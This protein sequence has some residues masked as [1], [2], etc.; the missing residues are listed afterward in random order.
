[1]IP[2]SIKVGETHINIYKAKIKLVFFVRTVEIMKKSIYSLPYFTTFLSY[3][4]L[5]DIQLK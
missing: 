3:S 4:V 1:M 2:C 5:C